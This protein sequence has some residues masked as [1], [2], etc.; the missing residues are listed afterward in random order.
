MDVLLKGSTNVI[1]LTRDS[2]AVTVSSCNF[3]NPATGDSIVDATVANDDTDTALSNAITRNASNITTADALTIDTS[4]QLVISTG[5]I[6]DIRVVGVSGTS[7]E[8]QDKILLNVASGTVKGVKSTATFALPAAYDPNSVVISWTLSDD[9]IVSDEQI[10]SKWRLYNPVKSQ[11]LYTRFSRLK[12]NVPSYQLASGFQPQIDSALQIIRGRFWLNSQV[13]DHARSPKQLTEL[14]IIQTSL[15]LVNM[16]FDLSA[17]QNIQETR[18]D[19]QLQYEQEINRIQTSLNF[20]RDD[21]ENNIKEETETQAIGW[22]I[23]I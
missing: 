16:N 6:I 15:I 23:R 22:R 20:W 17:S 11:D 21:D 2:Y 1:T 8:L 13:I 3:M 7:S 9:T 5:K 10:A 12:N 14:I 4:Y 19:L 18:E